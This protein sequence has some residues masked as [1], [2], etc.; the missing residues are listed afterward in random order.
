MSNKITKVVKEVVKE[1]LVMEN[2]FGIIRKEKDVEVTYNVTLPRDGYGSFEIF[3]NASGGE[4][5]YAEGGLWFRDKELTDYDGVFAL[6]PTIIAILEE[7]S[8]DCEYAK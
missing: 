4:S 5:W 8:Y 6:L 2:S 1:D 3:D 7:H